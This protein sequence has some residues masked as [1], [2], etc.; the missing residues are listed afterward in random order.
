MNS[1]QEEIRFYGP[2]NQDDADAALPQ[3]AVRWSIGVRRLSSNE[4][5]RGVAHTMMGNDEVAY[6]LPPGRNKVVGSYEDLRRK[7]HVFYFW[8]SQQNHSVVEFWPQRGNNGEVIELV[9]TPLLNFQ[10]DE[11]VDAASVQEFNYFTSNQNIPRKINTSWALREGKQVYELYLQK[12]QDGF[13]SVDFSLV[14]NGG[15]A[16]QIIATNFHVQTV[17]VNR[18]RTVRDVADS[19]NAHPAIS[20]VFDVEACGQFIKLTTVNDGEDWDIAFVASAFNATYATH[21]Q[22]LGEYQ[23]YTRNVLAATC[24]PP[25]C[26]PTITFGTDP[27]RQTNYIENNWFQFALI[28]HRE[29][30]EYSS[31]SQWSDV[32]LKGTCGSNGGNHL[33]VDLSNLR[34]S[35]P[36]EIV[37]IKEVEIIVRDR[38]LGTW[39][40]WKSVIRLQ[41]YDY[42]LEQTFKFF[43]D[44]DYK[45]LPTDIQTYLEHGMPDTAA[46]LQIIP[47]DEKNRMVLGN[48]LQNKPIDCLDVD[49]DIRYE[50]PR[51]G[52]AVV[53]AE[54]VI[55]APWAVQNAAKIGQPIHDVG[56]TTY[57]GGYYN[58]GGWDKRTTPS[59]EIPSGGI[60]L[61][62]AGMPI[63]AIS[64]QTQVPNLPYIS[65]TT[66]LDSNQTQ[67]VNT[68][69]A[70]MLNGL[71][72]HK[73]RLE[74]PGPGSYILRAP[75]LRCS[76]GNADPFLD[77]SSTNLLYQKTSS[78]TYFSQ[79]NPN[80]L[81][82]VD[83]NLYEVVITVPPNGGTITLGPIYVVDHSGWKFPW[84][85]YHFNNEGL[86]NS[87]TNS[88]R[89]GEPMELQLV[90]YYYLQDSRGLGVS[91]ASYT[92][93]PGTDY[94]VQQTGLGY[95]ENPYP[96][97]AQGPETVMARAITDH[98]GH[99]TWANSR[100]QD[101][102]LAIGGGV[103]ANYEIFAAV[104]GITGDP[105]NPSGSVTSYSYPNVTVA[106][107]NVLKQLDDEVYIGTFND[108]AL[109]TQATL[110]YGD[111]ISS[112]TENYGN[113]YELFVGNLSP[114]AHEEIR[115][116]VSQTVLDTNGNPVSGLVVAT[117]QGRWTT[118]STTGAFTFSIYGNMYNGT[119]VAANN[120]LRS[121]SIHFAAFNCGYTVPSLFYL[122]P[123]FEPLQQYSTTVGFD[124]NGTGFVANITSSNSPAYLARGAKYLLGMI[125][126]S[127]NGV[128]S[129]VAQTFEVYI[130]D[131][132]ENQ[133]KGGAIIDYTINHPVPRVER[134]EPYTHAA[135]LV[136]ENQTYTGAIEWKISDVRYVNSYDPSPQP[137]TNDNFTFSSFSSQH[138][139]IAITLDFELYN[140][141]EFN[142]FVDD[143]TALYYTWTRGDKMKV[144][145]DEFDNVFPVDLLLDIRQQRG[146]EIIIQSEPGLPEL[147][148]GMTIRITKLRQVSENETEIPLF[149]RP[150]C[151]VI[152][153]A[154]GSN[155]THGQSTGTVTAWDTHYV[156][157]SIPTR[158]YSNPNDTSL[159]LPSIVVK[160]G[161]FASPS[162]SDYFT[163]LLSNAGKQI[164]VAPQFQQKQYESSIRLSEAFFPDTAINGLGIWF[165]Q[166]QYTFPI[167]NGAIT[168]IRYVRNRMVVF[169]EY[170]V[171]TVYL[172]SVSQ[173]AGAAQPS[174]I[175][176]LVS[177]DFE[178]QLDYGCQHP[179]GIAAKED[180]LFWPDVYHTSVL[181]MGNN[182][183]HPIS[184][185]GLEAFWDE[186][187][188]KVRRL[189]Q[190]GEVVPI[191]G[192]FHNE[193]RE[194]ILT[195]GSV[196]STGDPAGG[197]VGSTGIPT[198]ARVAQ[199]D[200]LNAVTV[201][202]VEGNTQDTRG[203][204]MRVP[205]DPDWGGAIG[206]ELVTIKDEKFYIHDQGGRH[207]R[208][209]GID[210]VAKITTVF[211]RTNY[212]K[213][214]K[215][216]LA[217]EEHA[218][219]VWLVE[220]FEVKE[221][222]R[223]VQST[224]MDH[225]SNW[226]T[227]E[228]DHFAAVKRDVLSPN[229]PHPIVNGK[230][231]RGH[232]FEVTL[233]IDSRDLETLDRIFFKYGISHRTIR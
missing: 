161:V 192:F 56:G 60:P 41:R 65:G 61:Y 10:E 215:F 59:Q 48:V 33:V 82:N 71:I 144:L 36:T 28:Y 68:I 156:S 189:E 212:A 74:L 139:L 136:S 207:M 112:I 150:N 146:R 54:I 95:L 119:I 52:F 121:S 72:E 159:T 194:Y 191:V 226:K 21:A 49:F 188:R 197:G 70:A 24:N 88:L 177:N 152:S 208:F 53:E 9:R 181:K 172:G 93:N 222:G 107:L 91:S 98:N 198:G 15:T 75:D 23:G 18:P 79:C 37:D 185:R 176:R 115:T 47:D 6:T 129:T 50:E 127:E 170:K 154:Y 193:Y 122:I 209:Y 140:G 81:G 174:L 216:A 76:A 211:A 151:I 155:P 229:V 99:I 205:Y 220:S 1:Q 233:T 78:E 20:A 179:A 178:Q 204:E 228:N 55:I 45:V 80:G 101:T 94:I 218:S 27:D 116:T 57:L 110:D 133:I 73:I 30:G 231:I 214:R 58:S 8:N 130:P 16:G 135:F 201:S 145:L 12:D 103:I 113:G 106:N 164:P 17:F 13:T 38:Q 221:A 169:Q 123:H 132:T 84:K 202:W 171:F 39:S 11:F 124:F 148:P 183:V 90:E 134:G 22:V 62:V 4:G 96:S 118:T 108:T 182:G 40:N 180:L 213:A 109:T 232:S 77:L 167:R 46:T 14:A 173:D 92:A 217:I 35:N 165:G 163:S 126:R 128:G 120:N 147:K 89:D 162:P 225:P 5:Q 125:Y 224:R 141:T 51:D 158:T 203:W 210:T 85:Q 206:N 196:S 168:A 114:I 160:F 186:T 67:Y 195:V 184:A 34:L 66:I 142:A 86:Q 104:F 138:N 219:N 117:E 230:Q 175:N 44:G 190:Q 166:E 42:V 83:A 64:T 29:S 69:G 26:P 227:K 100:W 157:R 199:S 25:D 7:T 105:N 200:T 31:H 187:F 143:Q 153:Q 87:G 131:V 43:N 19:M 2:I 63:T 149:E 3:G 97:T 137:S 111:N 32:P 223:I 102:N